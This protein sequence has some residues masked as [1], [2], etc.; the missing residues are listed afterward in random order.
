M[1]FLLVFLANHQKYKD[2]HILR[3]LNDLQPRLVVF[4]VFSSFLS[5]FFCFP[6]FLIR[7]P[8]MTH[9]LRHVCTSK[10]R[11]TSCLFSAMRSAS[12]APWLLMSLWGV[13]TSYLDRL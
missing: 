6:L 13:V 11:P 2:T 9:P 12:V 7:G 8:F 10:L 3:K 4:S 1:V 5:L